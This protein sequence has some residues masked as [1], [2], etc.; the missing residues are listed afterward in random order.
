MELRSKLNEYKIATLDLIKAIEEDSDGMAYINKREELLKAIGEMSFSKDEL[1]S[2]YDELEIEKVDKKVIEL[3]NNE[4][5]K[6]KNEMQLLK[7]KRNA[8]NSYNNF[9][10]INLFNSRA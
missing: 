8:A 6:V 9:K 3:L 5:V 2:L 4:K 1:K 10:N 7:Q